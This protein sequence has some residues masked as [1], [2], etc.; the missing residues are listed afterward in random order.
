M[1]V[2]VCPIRGQAELDRRVLEENRRATLA[3]EGEMS[4]RVESD[5][6]RLRCEQVCI[7]MYGN[8][9]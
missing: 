1:C 9:L 8:G 4:A 6:W 7:Y 2:C 5:T 3:V